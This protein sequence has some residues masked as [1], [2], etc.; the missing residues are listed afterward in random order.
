MGL[1]LVVVAAFTAM[2]LVP[3]YLAYSTGVLPG[4]T[5]ASAGSATDSAGAAYRVTSLVWPEQALGLTATGTAVL[6]DQRDPSPDVAGLWSYD[7]RTGHTGQVLGRVRTGKAAGFPSASGEVIAWAAW[8]GRRGAGLPRIEAYDPDSTRRWTVAQAGHGLATAGDTVLW[9]ERRAGGDDAIRGSNS[10]TDEQYFVTAHGRVREIAA[11]GSWATWIGGRGKTR[12]VWAGS[13]RD[14]TPTKLAPAGT[15]VA[16][17]RDRI[18]WAARRP[19][20]TSVVSWDRRSSR[21]TLLCRV[22]GAVSSLSASPRYAAWITG[23][24]GAAPQVWAYDFDARRAFAV[25]PGDSRQASPVIVAD[26]VY[27][28]DDRSGDWELYARPLGR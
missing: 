25:S 8:A 20:S 6:W 22:D 3:G 10:L 1:R 15:A 27:W 23:G 14:A 18:L 11:W 19:H 5:Q 12:A 4:P 17:G 16:I 21:S 26:T 13:Y 24:K 9:V 28:A 7:V 2:V